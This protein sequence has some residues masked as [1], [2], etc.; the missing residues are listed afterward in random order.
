MEESSRLTIEY[1][2]WGVVEAEGWNQE[3]QKTG[4]PEMELL[5]A[6]FLDWLAALRQQ[7]VASGE[8]EDVTEYNP[9][10]NPL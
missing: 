9:L 7:A 4:L 10:A 2:V 1:L 5:E 8:K 6:G 3:V